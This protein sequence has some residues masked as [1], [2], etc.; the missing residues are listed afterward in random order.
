MAAL[1]EIVKIVGEHFI[2][3]DIPPP[4]LLHTADWPIF[5]ET[6]KGLS[7]HFALLSRMAGRCCHLAPSFLCADT[8]DYE[9]H[10]T[11]ERWGSCV[12]ICTRQLTGYIPLTTTY[13]KG[14]GHMQQP[15]ALQSALGSR[16]AHIIYVCLS[17]CRLLSV[18]KHWTV[19]WRNSQTMF[20]LH[21]YVSNVSSTSLFPWPHSWNCHFSEWKD[22]FQDD[23]NHC[24]T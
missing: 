3:P 20:T 12:Y 5:A 1:Q 8:E 11:K 15:L 16:S 24:D 2:S 18:W 17:I 10:A 4:V 19:Y 9:V 6:W 22:D 7:L 21:W 23:L 13:M 14:L